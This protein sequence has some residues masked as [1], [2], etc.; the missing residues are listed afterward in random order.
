MKS[1][2]PL[3]MANPTVSI[4]ALLTGLA[5]VG[6]LIAE[7]FESRLG[8]WIAKPLASTGFVAVGLEYGALDSSFGQWI[9]VGLVLCW[10]GDVLLIPAE[11]PGAFRLGIASFLLG[12]VAYAGAFTRVGIDLPSG[13]G[14]VLML[15]VVAIP[16]LRWLRPHV[17]PDF[18]VPVFAYVVVISLMLAAATGATVYSRCGWLLVGAGLF[19]FSD[20]AVARDRFVTP[21]FWNRAWGLPCYF[22]AQL[23]LAST[24]RFF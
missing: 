13:I 21:G 3:A 23:V 16:V 1:G 11:S 7:R 10:L 14:A 2:Y 4:F 12:H 6:L 8:I 24:P 18:V 9:L 17:P 19:Y 20:L 5:V 15:S 22:G